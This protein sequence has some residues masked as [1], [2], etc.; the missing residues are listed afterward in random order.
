[1]ESIREPS[2]SIARLQW[3][4]EHFLF[5]FFYRDSVSANKFGQKIMTVFAKATTIGWFWIS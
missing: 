4:L 1:M 3:H 2:Q 5:R